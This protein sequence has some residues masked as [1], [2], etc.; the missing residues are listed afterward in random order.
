MFSGVARAPVKKVSDENT[1]A[2]EIVLLI[3]M[4]TG[5]IVKAECT[6]STKIAGWFISRQLVGKHINKGP[7]EII[8]ILDYVYH[9]SEKRSLFAALR[10]I[11][12]KY[13]AF[14]KE[15]KQYFSSI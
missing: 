5:E 4:E 3:D 12:S 1:A 11:Y 7:E 8:K 10:V 6:F 2:I 9:G 14:V 13:M 15:E